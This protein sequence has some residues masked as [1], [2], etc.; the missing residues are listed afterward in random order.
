MAM[1]FMGL[2]GLFYLVGFIF[3]IIIIINAFKTDTTQGILCLCVPFYILYWVFAKFTHPKKGL[4]VAGFLG[5]YV[6]GAVL[7]GVSASMAASAVT[8]QMQMYQPGA[9]PGYPPQ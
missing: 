3:W 5:G 9:V 7:Y 8:D 6:L 2:G 4:I 1:V